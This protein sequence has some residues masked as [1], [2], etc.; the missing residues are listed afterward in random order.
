L[1]SA[2]N[3]GVGA[4]RFEMHDCSLQKTLRVVGRRKRLPHS[5]IG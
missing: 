2:E 3:D 1:K 4:E 5:R